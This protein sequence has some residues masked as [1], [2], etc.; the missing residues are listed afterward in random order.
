MENQNYIMR[1]ITPLSERDCFYIA[2]RRKTEFTY[3]IHCHAEYEL[4]F[5]EHASGV[6]RVVG[7]SAEIIG[8]YDLVLI[9]GKELEH[10]REQHECP[11]GENREITIQFS[12]DLFFGNVVNTNQ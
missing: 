12:P 1:E 10:V 2:D 8:D 9:T 11:S 3:P 5:T 7:D 6:R 4:N